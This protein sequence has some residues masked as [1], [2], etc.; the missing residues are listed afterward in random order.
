VLFELCAF[1]SA[2][3]TRNTTRTRPP[4]HPTTSPALRIVRTQTH[5]GG[6]GGGVK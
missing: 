2:R 4:T 1:Y 5:G 6:G 3:K